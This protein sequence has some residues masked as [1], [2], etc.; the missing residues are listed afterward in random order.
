MRHSLLSKAT[1]PV[2]AVIHGLWVLAHLGFAGIRAEPPPLIP[3]EVIFAGIERFSPKISPDGTKLGYL[4][5]H[6]GVMTVWIKALGKQ[7]ADQVAVRDPR[8]AVVDFAWQ[9]DGEHLLYVKDHDGRQNWHIY[10]THMQSQNTR[11]LTPFMGVRARLVASE[12]AFPNQ[13]LVAMN[14][15]DRTVSDVYRINL[16]HG[17]V[18][19]DT[20]NVG[21]VTQWAV[22]A[23]FQVRGAMATLED[24]S[25]EVRVRDDARSLWRRVLRWGAAE[26]PGALH[27]FSADSKSLMISTSLEANATRLIRVDLGTGKREVL[28]ED[29]TQD[30]TGLMINPSTRVLEAVQIS[31][32][33]EEWLVL[34]PMLKPHFEALKAVRDADFLVLSRDRSDRRWI[35]SYQGG[36]TGVT[37]YLYE[38]DSKSP[39]MVLSGRPLIEK[40]KLSSVKTISFAARDGLLLQ[41]YLTLPSGLEPRNLPMIVAVHAGPWARDG[42]LLNNEAQWLANRGYAVMQVNYRGSAGFG[43]RHLQAGEKE[44]GGKMLEDL[45]DAKNWAVKEG[46]ADSRRVGIYGASYGGYAVLAALAFA[47]REFACGVDL[48]GPS[49]LTTLV[50]S[51]PEKL[52]FARGLF[53]RRVGN[54]R[55]EPEFF[56]NRSPLFKA[57][58]IIKPLLIAQGSLDTQA[59]LEETNALVAA[60]RKSGASIEY[61]VFEDEGNGFSN[62]ANALKFYSACEQFLSK[63][64]G[65]RYEASQ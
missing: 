42:F 60:A 19:L 14:L 12:H 11:D 49:N 47:P 3:R 35:V 39:S 29:P 43:K 38:K 31:R 1:G 59:R 34:D 21:D 30:V 51:V 62:M 61:L 32:L 27:G 55:L 5:L 58:R 37:H 25:T 4:G 7:E 53:E 36:D 10:Q 50:E 9:A 24:G 22:D 46:Y 41:G 16:Q 8:T 40:L 26:G 45:L 15:R 33:R 63:H 13:I 56:Q 28:A 6:E 20:E 23:N 64:L 52:R 65:G 17:G 18:L 57:D 54:P 48:F 44:W 2:A